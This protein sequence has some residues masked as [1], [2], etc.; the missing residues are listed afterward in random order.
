MAGYN[1]SYSSQCLGL[2]YL[3]RFQLNINKQMRKKIYIHHDLQLLLK[4]IQRFKHSI[5]YKSSK[6][7]FFL[8]PETM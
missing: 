4:W 2:S 6:C 3:A 1:V 8:K 7:T 5:P